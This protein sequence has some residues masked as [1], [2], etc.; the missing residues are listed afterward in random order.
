MAELTLTSTILPSLL[1]ALPPALPPFYFMP[2]QVAWLLEEGPADADSETIT[3]CVEQFGVE[4]ASANRILERE[5]K[6]ARYRGLSCAPSC[7]LWS[8]V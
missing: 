4:E 1:P 5:F 2:I 8:G 7:P 6:E 3:D